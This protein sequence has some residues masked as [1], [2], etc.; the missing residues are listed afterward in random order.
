[1]KRIPKLVWPIGGIFLLLVIAGLFVYRASYLDVGMSTASSLRPGESVKICGIN[2]TQDYDNGEGTWELK[3]REGSFIE[4][5]ET[6]TLTQV[7]LKLDPAGNTAFTIRG[8]EGNYCRRSGRITF[9]GDVMGKTSNGY[10]IETTL[11]IYSEKGGCVETDEPI[12]VFGPFFDVKG[13]GLYADLPK[14]TFTVK[15]NVCTTFSSGVL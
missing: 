2:Y 5:S 7:L 11:L 10:R 6:L 1:M 12:R 3:A 14:G 13:D 9:R 15:G 8:N 4:K